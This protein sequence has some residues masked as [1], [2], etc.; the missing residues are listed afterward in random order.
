YDYEWESSN[1]PVSAEVNLPVT[2]DYWY[3]RM[4]KYNVSE[5]EFSEIDTVMSIPEFDRLVDS[6][7]SDFRADASLSDWYISIHWVLS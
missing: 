3:I 7:L 6:L 1:I 2:G 4:H 5:G